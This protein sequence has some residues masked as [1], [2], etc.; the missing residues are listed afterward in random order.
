MYSTTE[1]GFNYGSGCR[2]DRKPLVS[3]GTD[4]KQTQTQTHME[5]HLCQNSSMFIKPATFTKPRSI[6]TKHRSIF[7]EHDR[8]LL[9]MA[10][11]G[12]LLNIDQ[13]LVKIDGCL[14]KID[15]YL[16]MINGLP[17]VV[18]ID[19]CLPK[20]DRGLVN[21]MGLM[22]ITKNWSFDTNSTPQT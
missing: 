20:I 11:H 6:F 19:Q 1:R 17:F 13:C 10:I 8:S 2:S 22:N 16:V 18:Q 15:R 3:P 14:A 4:R 5:C 9:E 7:S 12:Y 21:V